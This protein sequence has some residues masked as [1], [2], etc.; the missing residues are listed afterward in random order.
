M[1]V[2]IGC[3]VEQFVSFPIL[4]FR[5]PGSPQTPIEANCIARRF[6]F[7]LLLMPQLLFA[8]VTN[9]RRVDLERVA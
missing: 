1:S 4:N 7:R 2:Q 5:R 3:A 8:A 9:L 6:R